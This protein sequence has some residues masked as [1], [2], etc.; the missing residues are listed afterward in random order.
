MKPQYSEAA[1]R[2][3]NDKIGL[4]AAVDATV[5]EALARKF[6]IQGFPT[7]KFFENG[8]FKKDYEGK[9]TPDDLYNFVKNGGK[10]SS[11]DEL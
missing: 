7:L 1:K 4:L 11:K 10:G 6:S 3:A 8:V 5:S 9:R 2:V